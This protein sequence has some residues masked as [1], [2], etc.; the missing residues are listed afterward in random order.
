MTTVQTYATI[1]EAAQAPGAILGGGTL[2]MRAVN[3]APQEVEALVRV[4]DPALR[5]VRAEGE[6]IRIGAGVTMAGV[7][8]HPDLAALAPAAR[9]IGGPALR[10]MATVGGNLFAPHPYGDLAVGLLALGAL[11]HLA[12]GRALDLAEFLRQRDAARL[13]AAVSVPRVRA[14]ALR[15]R[16][17]SRTRP[18]GASVLSIAAYLVTMGS[19]VDHATIA[20]GAMG[21]T[22]LRAMGAERALQGATLDAS[23]VAA[24]CAAC[25]QG[26]APP[27]DALASAWY[28]SEVAPVHLRR[29]LLGES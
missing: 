28:R 11:V 25:L 21:P 16:K 29:L 14:E 5:E 1:A 26:L 10:N 18:K 24:A 20:F 4:T 2:L 27:D 9:A 15:F 3:Y 13:V 6:R 22:P 23:G 7:I 19:R 12:D 8:A 17:V